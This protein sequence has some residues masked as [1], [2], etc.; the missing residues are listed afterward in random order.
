MRIP[1]KYGQS[2]IDKC[3][4]C[5]QQ[6]V[7]VNSQKV[8]VCAKHKNSELKNLRCICGEYLD[9]KHGK[10]G[11]FFTCFNCGNMNLK[12]VLE[13]NRIE[14]DLKEQPSEQTVTSDDPRYF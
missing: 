4:F 12:K 13:I 9:I 2:R 1:K 5:G 6:S 14:D 8:P 7:T 10:Y 11:A 3:P